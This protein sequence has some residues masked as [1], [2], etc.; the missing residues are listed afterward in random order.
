VVGLLF[1]PV[2]SS[3]LPFG[4][5]G[6]I[7]ASIM[8]SDRWNAGAALMQAGNPGAWGEMEAADALLTSNKAALKLC[9]EAAVRSKK[10]QRCT[11]LVPP[12]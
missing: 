9:R 12:S 7:A 6:R 1:S 11:V 3:L 10:E 4:L 5:D 2:L 8:R